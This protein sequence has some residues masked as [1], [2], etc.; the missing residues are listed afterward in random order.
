MQSISEVET[1][2]KSSSDLISVLPVDILIGVLPV[3]VAVTSS[4]SSRYLTHTLYFI[5]LPDL[6]CFEVSFP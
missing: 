2:I 3:S 6:F 1:E 4:F 5:R